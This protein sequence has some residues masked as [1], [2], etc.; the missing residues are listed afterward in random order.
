MVKGQL[1]PSPCLGFKLEF[2][3]FQVTEFNIQTL[4]RVNL[5]PGERKVL[6]IS[7][8]GQWQESGLTPRPLALCHLVTLLSQISALPLL[9]GDLPVL[10]SSRPQ[11]S[12]PGR[13]WPGTS[14]RHTV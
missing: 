3:P 8:R 2:L 13:R 9:P 1:G 6:A 14:S 11:R 4:Q 10:R 5:S 7:D 12:P